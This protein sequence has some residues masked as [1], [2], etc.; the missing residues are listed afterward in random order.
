M[1]IGH[2]SFRTSDS[3][4]QS[5]ATRMGYGYP[6]VD[7]VELAINRE[8]AMSST[9]AAEFAWFYL[10]SEALSKFS[11]NSPASSKLRR[12][13]AEASFWRSEEACRIANGRLVDPWTRCS[14]NQRVLRRARTLVTSV[15]GP[16]PW[17]QFSWECGFGPGASLGLRRQ[18]SSQQNKWVKSAHITQTAIP[19]FAAFRRWAGLN[20]LPR[21]GQLKIAQGNRITTV[22]KSWKTDRIIAVEPDWN[23]FF[24]KGVGG[25]IRHR[26]QRVGLLKPDAQETNRALAR[27]GSQTGL[28]ATLDLS[29]ASDSISLALCEALLP[30]DWF[31]VLLD[32]RSPEGVLPSGTHCQYAKISPLS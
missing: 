17:E 31:R 28:L 25:L 32:L 19:Y 22:P 15:L 21:I 13:A 5:L 26:L 3:I 20:T 4:I 8:F 9:S 7:P 2:P 11:N 14:L 24:Q 10:C 18:A 30:E 27:H 6:D 29:A 1:A 16:F 12:E 23:M